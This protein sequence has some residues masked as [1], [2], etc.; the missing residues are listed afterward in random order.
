MWHVRITHNHPL[1]FGP[2]AIE[3]TK[4]QR[5]NNIYDSIYGFRL[6]I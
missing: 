4:S 3:M 1:Y 5:K 6:Q 2:K